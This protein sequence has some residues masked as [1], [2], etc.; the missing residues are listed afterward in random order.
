MMYQSVQR[1]SKLKFPAVF[2]G[3]DYNPEQWMVD[4]NWREIWQED[5]RLMRKA[6]VNLVSLGIFSWAALQPAE[7][8]FTFEWLDDILELLAEQQIFACLGTAT[9]AQPAWLSVAYPDVLP[10]DETGVRHKPGVRLNYCPTNEHFRRLGQDLVRRLAERYRDHRALL[11][12]HVSNEYGPACYCDHCAMRF[13]GWLQQRYGRLDELNRHWITSI[14]SRTYTAWEQV[15]PPSSIGEH[16]LPALQIDYQHFLSDMNLEGYLG[17]VAILRD[18]TPHVPVMTN[19]HGLTRHIDYFSWAQHQDIISWDS[20]PRY[21][22]TPDVAAFHYDFMRSLKQKQPWL[23]L[24]QTPSQVQWH[25]ENPLKRP[26]VMRLQ[27]YQALAHGSN[28]V[29][30]FQWRQARGGREMYHGAIVGHAGHEQTRIFQEV[31]ALG[32]ELKLLEPAL[33]ETHMQARVALMMSWPNWWAVENRHTPSRHFNYIAELQHY[34]RALWKRNIAVD[35]ISPDQPLDN[36][37]LVIAPLFTMVSEEQGAAIEQYVKEGGTFLTTYFSGMVDESHRAWLGGF[38]GPLRRTLGIWVE[39]FDPLPAGKTNTL[40]CLQE[41]DDWSGTYNCEHWCDIVQLEGAQAIAIFGQD[42]YAGRPAITEYHYGLGQAFYVATRPDAA[43]VDALMKMLQ[44]RLGLTAPLQVPRG[45]EVTR[46]EGKMVA[47]FLL[48][49]LQ[50]AQ[51]ITLSE[52]MRDVLTQYIYEQVIQ[53][54]AL[55]VAIL[56][57]VYQ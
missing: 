10:V 8:H 44:S 23:L 33:L 32:A 56:I 9:A 54:P 48:N 15:Q 2:Y 40:F 24:E 1:G 5:V 46:R 55:G 41:T 3:G 38:P 37:Q 36:Y 47:Y 20:Y 30:F 45:V 12:W 13:R 51:C 34:Y 26:G 6:G 43:G 21:N 28:S 53:L 49:H 42:F 35:I 57:P 14:W 19:F 22:A 29:M 16:S 17:E 31:A 52:P 39:E 18:V 4:K 25:Q 11:L 50:E 7:D 27:S